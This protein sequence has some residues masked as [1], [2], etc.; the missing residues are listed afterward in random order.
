MSFTGT[1]VVPVA[2]QK[3]LV[4]NMS[5]SV[6]SVNCDAYRMEACWGTHVLSQYCCG[7]VS[8][9]QQLAFQHNGGPRVQASVCD[10]HNWLKWGLGKCGITWGLSRVQDWM[11]SDRVSW[12]GKRL[13]LLGLSFWP[14]PKNYREN[15]HPMD[16]PVCVLCALGRKSA[17][18]SG[19]KKPLRP[20][21]G[22]DKTE[23]LMR[24]FLTM[25]SLIYVVV[26]QDSAYL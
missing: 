7:M 1:S 6:A 13:F 5:C 2:C 11:E 14:D 17:L 26:K 4:G 15:M 24:A 3:W 10:I 16:H 8:Q 25:T 18:M 19:G 20:N 9:H 21:E 23:R 22:G 12:R